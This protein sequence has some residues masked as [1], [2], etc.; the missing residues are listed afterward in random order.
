MA[1]AFCACE[2][3]HRNAPAGDRF[4]EDLRFRALIPGHVLCALDRIAISAGRSLPEAI[5]QAIAEYCESRGVMPIE[6]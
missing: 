4:P 6:V 3:F 2:P 5:E 1:G